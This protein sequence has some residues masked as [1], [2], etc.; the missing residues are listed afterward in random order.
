MLIRVWFGA[1][2]GHN[3]CGDR[4]HRTD[5]NE[6]VYQRF[7]AGEELST[8]EAQMLQD[9]ELITQEEKWEVVGWEDVHLLI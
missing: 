6:D 7:Q 4:R 9:L 8:Q 3:G 5:E 1:G 2:S